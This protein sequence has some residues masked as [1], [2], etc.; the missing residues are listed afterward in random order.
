MYSSA[1]SKKY[2]NRTALEWLTSWPSVVILILTILLSSGTIIHSQL[3]KVGESTWNDYYQLRNLVE[4][5]CDLEMDIESS[6]ARAIERKKIEMANDPLAG[7]LGSSEV[8]ADSIRKSIENKQ[9][10]CEKD[11][12]HY[13]ELEHRVTPSL[14]YFAMFEGGFAFVVTKLNDYQKLL[15]ALLVLI[16]AAAAAITRHHISLRPIMTERDF[17][18]STWSQLIANGILMGSSIVYTMVDIES[19]N[20]GVEVDDFYLHHVWTFGFGGLMLISALQLFFRP[21]DLE[22]GGGMKGAMLT[23]PLYAIMCF[24]ANIQFG[25][26]GYWQGTVVYLNM[27]MEFSTMFLNLALYGW[28]GMMLTQTRMMHLLFDVLRPWKM[29]PELLSL[30]VLFIV[31]FPTAYTGASGI[32]VLAAGAVIYNELRRGGARKQLALGATAMSG[33]MGVVLAPCLLMVIIAA[34]NKD[35]TTSELFG[36]GKVLFVLTLIMYFLVSQLF[37]MEPIR[38]APVREA[39]P[40]SLKRLVPLIPYL[41]VFALVIMFFAYAL[42]R[43]M[44]EFSAPIILPVALLVILFYDYVIK[45]PTQEELEEARKDTLIGDKG[46]TFE[47]AVRVA[48]NQ[49]CGPIGALLILMALSVSSSGII[50]RIGLVDMLPD[51]FASKWI[52]MTVVM[53]AMVLI[54]MFIDP[55]GAIIVVNATIFHIAKVNGLDPLH[56]WMMSLMCFELG[57]LMPPIALNHLLARQVIGYEEVASAKLTVGSFWRRYEKFLMPILVV[58][59]CLLMVAYLPLASDE[60][61]DFVFKPG[62][63]PEMLSHLAFWR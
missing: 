6:V 30:I 17:T 14:Q 48:T 20:K 51:E 56:F 1:N 16:C 5:T 25:L 31:A 21:K 18:V 37:R 57:Y 55:Y 54:G 40:E 44:D 42:G 23:V 36:S 60:I 26:E 12:A 10:R 4:P 61:H 62:Y 38:I 13:Q 43:G 39:L 3:S 58:L 11:W 63:I 41:V 19:I 15:L 22:K 59:P 24:G 50:E 29:S 34:L 8:N 53:L 28:V 49:T 32:F 45:K 47:E 9:I 27:M 35:V 52:A 7:L 46:E 33:S 2:A